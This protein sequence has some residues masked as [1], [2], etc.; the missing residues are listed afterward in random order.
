M[1]TYTDILYV[2]DMY[3]NIK[4]YVLSKKDTDSYYLRDE[5]KIVKF[6]HGTTKSLSLIF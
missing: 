5:L 6:F 3:T 4:L 1:Y 2:M